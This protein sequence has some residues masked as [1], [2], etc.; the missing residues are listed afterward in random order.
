MMK[1]YVYNGIGIDDAAFVRGEAPMTKAE[2]RAVTISKLKPKSG[3]T[4]VD[5][6]AGTGSVSVECAFLA[7]RV[8]AVECNEAAVTLVGE[9]AKNFGLKNIEVVAGMAPQALEDIG[10]ADCVFIGGSKGSLAPIMEW[11]NT[12][13]N[14]D[15]RIAANFITL[16]NATEFIRLLRQKGYG[17]IDIVQIQVNKGKDVGNVTMLQAQNPVFIVSGVRV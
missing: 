7:K 12:A 5:I 13:V 8:I 16:E 1:T 15:G 3:D 6:G 14:T 11:A 4:V 2:V 10:K 9:N 17:R